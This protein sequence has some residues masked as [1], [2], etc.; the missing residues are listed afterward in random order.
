MI[1]RRIS[2]RSALALVATVVTV[3]FAI[4]GVIAYVT[5]SSFSTTLG[6]SAANTTLLRYSSQI[7]EHQQAV[8]STVLGYLIAYDRGDVEGLATTRAHYAEHTKDLAAS[9]EAI[10]Q[11]AMSKEISAA[12]DGAR[13]SLMAFARESETLM[14]ETITDLTSGS[15]RMKAYEKSFAD[16][17]TKLNVFAHVIEKENLSFQN[18]A[19][20][21]LRRA[22][23]AV[24]LSVALCLATLGMALWWLYRHI[25]HP[26][27][28]ILSATEDLRAGDGDLTKRLPSL[29]G[30]FGT[31]STSM[32]GF[33]SQLH[34]LIAVVASNAGEIAT[35]A[36]QIST[37]NSE[38]SSRTEEQASTLEETASIMGTFT[39]SIRQN[40]QSTKTASELAISATGAAQRG[41]EVAAQAVARITSANANSRKIGEIVTTIDS[42]AF[43]TNI[44]AL[45]AAVES[46]RAGENGRGFA[47]VASEVRALAHRSAASAKEI[48]TL[49]G[50]AVAEVEEGAKLVGEVGKAVQDII[51]SIQQVSKIIGEI[52][53][54][55][56]EQATGIEQVNNAV[57]QMDHVTQ[58]NAALVE[59]AAAAA[60]A[61]R[62]QAEALTHLVSR[63][64]V[65]E[66]N[67]PQREQAGM[68]ARVTA[69]E[70]ATLEA[71]S[72]QLYVKGP[73]KAAVPIKEDEWTEF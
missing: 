18:G 53:N 47:V 73:K 25:A 39:T 3:L 32:N 16:V 48:K 34:D 30:E 68:V 54:V 56:S 67:S 64:K 51:A 69:Q 42:I 35:A 17:S 13:Q 12:F 26:I 7:L 9:I 33:V 40:A 23:M 72:T 2:I 66:L 70:P 15:T 29:S 1:S 4:V 55:S 28:E 22:V 41:G 43:Q 65:D 37:G 36:Q 59:E 52:S 20:T 71:P 46:A 58:Q 62:G 50:T 6:E 5:V 60:E 11:L 27:K 49:I 57:G 8:R 45:N 31:V 14:G 38:L 21:T 61:M 24:L 10:G 63:F 19:N 44:L